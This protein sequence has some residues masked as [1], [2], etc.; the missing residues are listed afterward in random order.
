MS[1]AFAKVT[2]CAAVVRRRL[3]WRAMAGAVVAAGLISGLASSACATCGDWLANP[4]HSMAGKQ[5]EK[6]AAKPEVAAGHA[7]L[8]SP[9]KGRTCQKAPAAPAPVAPGGIEQ[10]DKILI[11]VE[12]SLDDLHFA[13]FSLAFEADAHPAKGF[14]PRIEHPPRA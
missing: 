1:S 10:V 8:P 5:S 3:V 12:A 9:C 4:S 6:S 14:L 11:A 2:Q 7:P 13:Q